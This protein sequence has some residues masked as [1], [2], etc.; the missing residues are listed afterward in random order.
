MFSSSEII[1][2]ITGTFRSCFGDIRQFRHFHEI[3]TAMDT[4]ERTSIAHLNST[5]MDHVNQS[6]M[7]RVLSPHMD[8]ERMFTDTIDLINREG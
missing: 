4:T 6:N 5:I 7:N 8:T 1:S 2:E 3:I